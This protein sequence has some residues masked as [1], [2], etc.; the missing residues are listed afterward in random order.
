MH[1]SGILQLATGI[2]CAAMVQYSIP[3]YTLIISICTALNVPD[4][5]QTPLLYPPRGYDGMS[6][7][8]PLGQ[9]QPELLPS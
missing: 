5:A 7:G 6:G 4:I 9:Q 1:S 8:H 3:K 2:Q